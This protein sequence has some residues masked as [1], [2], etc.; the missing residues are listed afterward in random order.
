M[1]HNKMAPRPRAAAAPT[2]VPWWLAAGALAVVILA[3]IL[4]LFT[5]AV[6]TKNADDYDAVTDQST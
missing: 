1:C 2:H 5:P 3:V 4:A 6:A